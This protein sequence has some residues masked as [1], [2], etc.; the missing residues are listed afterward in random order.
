MNVRENPSTFNVQRSTLNM[1]TRQERVK[2]LLKREISDILW[3]ELRDPRLGFVTIIDAEVT[4]DLQHAVIFVSVMGDDEQKAESLKVLQN[5]SRYIRG[6]FGRRVSMKVTP[7]LSFKFDTG[8]EHGMRMFE[9]LQ[10]VKS[11]EKE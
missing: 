10:K 7:E 1:S 6:E 2:E 11:D 5:A 3:R 8:V 9:L 4:K